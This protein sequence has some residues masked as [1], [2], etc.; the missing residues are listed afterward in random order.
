MGGQAA[1]LDGGNVLAHAVHVSDRG[2]RPQ[3]GP[4]NLSFFGRAHTF[5]RQ[6]QQRRT[7]PGNQAKQK[8]TFVQLANQSENTGGCRFSGR[9]RYRMG[10]FDDLDPSAI[11]AMG[12]PGDHN[13]FQSVKPT[14][15]FCRLLYAT[16]HG[17]RRFA[18]PH[19]DN[20]S[21]L[22]NRGQ[23]IAHTAHGI[24]GCKRVLEQGAQ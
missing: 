17:G 9:I 8:I 21:A 1:S 12:V 19:H 2:A 11:H 4:V 13:P 7:T 16:R 23:M 18:S 15:R 20:A 22:G 3:Q 14:A 10:G 24:R 6:C 5:G